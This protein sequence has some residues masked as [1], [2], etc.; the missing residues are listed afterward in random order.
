M[1][2]KKPTKRSEDWT[3][4][5]DFAGCKDPKTRA[6]LQ[7]IEANRQA[8]KAEQESL[9]GWKTVVKTT[10]KANQ[11]LQQLRAAQRYVDRLSN[12]LFHKRPPVNFE[13]YVAAQLE[14]LFADDIKNLAKL[15]YFTIEFHTTM[16]DERVAFPTQ[17]RLGELLGRKRRQIQIAL[18]QLVDR[19]YVRV[20]LRRVGSPKKGE[21]M[22]NCYTLNLT[23]PRTTEIKKRGVENDAVSFS[24][25]NG[26]CKPRRPLRGK[27]RTT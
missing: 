18:K 11:L 8:K 27:Q 15:L 24:T 9:F 3:P 23:D 21:K 26:C 1:S 2:T 22:I 5:N 10:K 13:P 20:Q 25:Q 16:S 4:A 7:R 19:G 17:D 12:E 6:T 14:V